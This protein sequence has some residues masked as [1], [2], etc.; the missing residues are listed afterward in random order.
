MGK[1]VYHYCSMESFLN[2]IR[3]KTL[4][5]GDPMKMN[6]SEEIIVFFNKIDDVYYD[7]INKRAGTRIKKADVIKRLQKYG[8]DS[9]FVASFSPDNDNLNLWARYADKCNGVAIGFDFSKVLDIENNTLNLR[10]VEYIDDSELSEKDKLK[11]ELETRAD[12]VEQI[13]T[14]QAITESG[15]IEEI[16]IKIFLPTIVF[17]KNHYYKSE[18][19][20][21]LMYDS[22][23][24]YL[25][26]I[27]DCDVLASPI[28]CPLKHGFKST[29]NNL[30]EYVELD[31]TNCISSVVLGSNCTLSVDEAVRMI[32]AIYG[33]RVMV[34]KSKLTYRG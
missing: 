5:L 22:K 3:S 24:A 11:N 33:T 14:E 32:E 25:E 23:K 9:V 20:S 15:L 26:H 34:E 13:I 12:E 17:V 1:V 8:N 29:S 19:E 30:I 31:I 10:K 2:I 16:F 27:K 6:D 28:P 4:R 7:R 21:R 18:N